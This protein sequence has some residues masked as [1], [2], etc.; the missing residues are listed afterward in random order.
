[1]KAKDIIL[2]VVLV[3]VLTFLGGFVIGVTVRS[4]GLPPPQAVLALVVSNFVFSV[5][6]F[7]ITGVRVKTE[8]FK[9]LFVVALICWL[10]SALNM[11]LI[12]TFT[13]VQWVFSSVFILVTMGI[14]GGLSYLFAPAVPK[15]NELEA[16]PP[17]PP[18]FA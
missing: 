6:A 9:T 12:P 3:C 1:M 13:P 4:S 14:G 18:D 2:G 8:R 10:L 17:Q 16:T 15:Q 11:L 5:V 7:C